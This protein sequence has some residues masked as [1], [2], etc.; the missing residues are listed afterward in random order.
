MCALVIGGKITGFVEGWKLSDAEVAVRSERSVQ[1]QVHEFVHG[2]L[3]KTTLKC[4]LVVAHSGVCYLTSVPRP[5]I[6][7]M[8]RPSTQCVFDLITPSVE[9]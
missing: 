4:N 5:S 6:A 1:P 7:T 3:I 9:Q 2:L 8:P